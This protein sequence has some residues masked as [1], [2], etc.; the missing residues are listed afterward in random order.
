MAR[1][2]KPRRICMLPPNSAFF[3]CLPTGGNTTTR[4]SVV[5]TLEEY[6][7]LRLIDYEGGDQAACADAMGVART[8]VQAIY[9]SARQR[10]ATALVCGLPLEIAGGNYEV[11]GRPHG[12]CCCAARLR[13]GCPRVSAKKRSERTMKLA[14]TYSPDGTIFQ[15]F[16]KTQAFKVY[17]IEKGA[18]KSAEVKD[19]EGQGHGALAGL[20]RSWGV[21][22]LICGGMGMGARNAL[23]DAGIDIYAGCTGAA[24]D[25]ANALIA[26]TLAK[27]DAATCD[28]HHGEHTCHA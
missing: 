22:T 10:V 7:C 15:H 27:S 4:P 14:I 19:T 16:G 3:P 11:C 1:P 12:D 13:H 9:A 24:D 21:D 25:A 17:D 2:A 6:E 23:A 26:G 18:V 8:T 5:L 20:L 28:H